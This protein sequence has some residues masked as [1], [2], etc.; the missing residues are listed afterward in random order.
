MA[1][2]RCRNGHIYDPEIY[3]ENCPYCDKGNSS[4]DFDRDFQKTSAPGATMGPGS[5]GS[6]YGVSTPMD[7]VRPDVVKKTTA[8][9]DYLG[10]QQQENVGH[11]TA[12]FKPV[13][14]GTSPVVG[15]LVCIKGEDMGKDYRLQGKNNEIGRGANM[16]VQITGDQTITSNVHAKIDYDVLNNDFYLLPGNNKNTI[17]LNMEP[18]YS[19][20][21]LEPYDKIRFGLTELLFVPFCCDRF[22]WPN[23]SEET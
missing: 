20:K 4:I 23:Q 18:V 1:Q 19:A 5:T 9:T 12:V 2:A 8:P 22:T 15:W 14:S 6:P 17:Y 10:G 7:T 11:T 3:G 21:K 13:K 16:D